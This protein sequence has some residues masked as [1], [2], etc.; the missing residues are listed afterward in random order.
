MQ[1]FSKQKFCRLFIYLYIYFIVN[2]LGTVFHTTLGFRFF[3]PEN[4]L[5]FTTKELFYIYIYLQCS[6]ESM[7]TVRLNNVYNTLLTD[8]TVQFLQ[9][10]VEL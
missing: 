8:A 2:L 9:R 3:K 5:L 10:A 1:S 7:N 4:E 6:N